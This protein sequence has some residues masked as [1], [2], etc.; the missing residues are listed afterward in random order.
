MA[1][2]DKRPPANRRR[3]ATT[4]R[5][6]IAVRRTIADQVISLAHLLG[7]PVRDDAG[8]R[9]GRVSD[10]VVRWDAGVAHPAVVGVVVRVGGSDAFVE[11]ADVTLHQTEARLQSAQQTVSRRVRQPGDVGLARDVLDRQL[12][13]VAGVQVIRAADVYMVNGPN[14][15]ELAGVEVGLRSFI[16]RLLLKARVCPPPDRA[17][18]WADLQAFVPRFT[19]TALPGAPGPAA[20]A[21]DI[22]GGVQ[23]ARPAAELTK[24]RAADV[25]AILADL[26]R[27]QQAQVAALAAPS[28]AAEALRELDPARRDALLA[29]LSE[30]D[31]VRLQALLDGGQ[32]P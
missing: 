15:W 28:A 31:R 1:E 32:A 10:I 23:F 20:A 7:R 11:C 9:V 17:I 6:Q 13:D 12:V 19:D 4:L 16:R 22:G 26:G 2:P 14:G 24:L 21:G 25:A 5:E 18:D 3:P 30:T 8:A 27:G 29:E